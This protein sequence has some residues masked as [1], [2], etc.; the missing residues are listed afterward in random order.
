MDNIQFRLM[1]N[2]DEKSSRQFVTRFTNEHHAPFL[3]NSPVTGSLLSSR[4][5]PSQIL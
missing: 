3:S 4:L 1:P 5:H 2:D